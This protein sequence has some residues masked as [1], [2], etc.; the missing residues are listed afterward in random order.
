MYYDYTLLGKI[1]TSKQI[2]WQ[3]KN[4]Q[5]FK[6]GVKC[7]VICCRILFTHVEIQCGD[8]LLVI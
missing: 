4:M 8:F 1:A 2:N 6:Y 5:A 7:S 3:D